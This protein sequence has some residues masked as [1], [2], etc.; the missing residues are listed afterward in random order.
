MKSILVVD[1]ERSILNGF[2]E[3]LESES[4]SVE[5]AET[6][7]EAIEK[8]N[9]KFF[10]LA[11]IDIRLPDIDGT[12]LLTA[13]KETMPKMVKI[14]VTGYPSQENAIESLNKGADGY[15]I[16]PILNMDGL[17]NMVKEH[18]KKQE[19]VKNYIEGK[20][21]EHIKKRAG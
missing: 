6:G 3:V 11:L 8:S 9:A 4:F 7:E 16:K 2:K 15:I 20:V 18:L 12:K 10:N 17:V 13:M 19:E 14:M 5:T 21:K 1:D